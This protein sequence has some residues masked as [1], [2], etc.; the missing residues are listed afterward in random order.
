MCNTVLFFIPESPSCGVRNVRQGEPVR[1][2]GRHRC[3]QDLPS[4]SW[5][6]QQEWLLSH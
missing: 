3:L 4:I 1:V 5:H 2:K 6:H